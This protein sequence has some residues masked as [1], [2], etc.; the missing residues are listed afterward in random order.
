MN[1]TKCRSERVLTEGQ[2]DG[3]TKITCQECGYSTVKDRQGRRM[4]TDAAPH[5][6]TGRLLTETA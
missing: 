6:P 1:C 5:P 4:L 2:G 3:K